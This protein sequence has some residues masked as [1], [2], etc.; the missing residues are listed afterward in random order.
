MK[1]S[2]GTIVCSKCKTQLNDANWLSSCK[3]R[4][5]HAC[6]LCEQKRIAKI[7]NDVKNDPVRNE[8][9]NN[10]RKINRLKTRIEVMLAYGNECIKCKESGILFLTLDHINNNGILDRNE[11]GAGVDFYK[12]LKRNGYPGKGTQLQIL[13]H[14]CNALKEIERR[15]SGAEKNIIKEVY[16]SQPYSISKEQDDELWKMARDLHKKINQRKIKQ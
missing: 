13:C 11:M 5:L 9:K 14:N 8:N 10:V 3:K 6:R 4:Y 15:K 1:L 2:D 7:K 16:V 12:F